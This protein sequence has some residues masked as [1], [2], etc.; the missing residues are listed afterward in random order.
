MRQLNRFLVLVLFILPHFSEAQEGTRNTKTGELSG[1]VLLIPFEPKLYMSEIDMKI[2][3]QTKWNFEQIREN[4]RH[5]LDNQLKSKLQN[6]SSVV[7]FYTD[8]SKT[9]K[10]LMYMYKSTSLG[11]ELV[12]KSSKPASPNQKQSGIINGQLQVEVNN[13]KKF[14]TARIDDKEMLTYF[15]NKYK[16]EYFVFINELDL[17]SV[18]ES[19]NLST[20]SYLREATV[21]YTIIDKAGKTIS[22]GLIPTSFSSKENNPKKISNTCFVPIASTIA[23]R[24]SDII[25]PKPE[26]TQKK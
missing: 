8:S 15:N 5:Q 16:T 13:D 14:M 3:Q 6:I 17:K 22:S 24:L 26:T 21:H 23:T 19:Y 1:K 25:N 12:E 20:D 9:W 10:D 7:S 18:P 11:F 4:F 2:N